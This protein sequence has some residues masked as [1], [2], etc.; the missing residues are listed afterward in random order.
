MNGIKETI[1]AAKGTWF[2]CKDAI[3]HKVSRL[4]PAQRVFIKGAVVGAAATGIVVGGVVL[5]KRRAK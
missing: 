2:E 5:Y 3:T 1:E 4:T